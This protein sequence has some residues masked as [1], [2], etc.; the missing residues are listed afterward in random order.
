ML[1]LVL[2]PL[3]CSE[4]AMRLLQKSC[5][6]DEKGVCSPVLPFTGVVDKVDGVNLWIKNK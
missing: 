2:G 1:G 6:R 3:C 4:S 5:S